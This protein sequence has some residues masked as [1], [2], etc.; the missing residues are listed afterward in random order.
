MFEVC[1]VFCLVALA[2]EPPDNGQDMD[3][4]TSTR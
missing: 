2:Y 1:N 3:T 4:Y